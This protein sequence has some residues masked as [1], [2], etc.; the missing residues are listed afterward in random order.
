[1]KKVCRDFRLRKWK[2][3]SKCSWEY[4]AKWVFSECGA[5]M[6]MLRN[7]QVKPWGKGDYDP[8]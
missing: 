7:D 6:A 3:A 8:K 5:K 1:M 4:F 2:N